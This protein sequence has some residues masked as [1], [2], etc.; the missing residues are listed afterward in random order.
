[1][2]KLLILFIISITIISCSSFG[3]KDKNIITPDEVL[4]AVETDNTMLLNNFF[5]SDFPIGYVNKEGKSLLIIA[6]EN[7]SQK[8]LNMLLG[9]GVYLEETF[10]DG[11]TPIFYVRSLNALEQMVKAGADINKK[12]SSGKTLLS[13]FIEAKPLSYS[14]YLTE[15]GADV[16]AVEENGWTP[17]FRA[18]AGRDISLLEAM[19]N[20][21]GNFT[22]QDLAGNFPI[23]YA[24]NEEILLKLLDSAKYNLNAKNKKEE[25]ILGEIYLRAVSYNYVSVIEKLLEVG[26]NPNYMSYGDSALSIARDNRNES[27]I[28][29]LNSKG[30]K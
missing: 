28:K 25:N 5:A 21:G 7:D 10:E 6:L 12:D 11:K 15:Q 14:K 3:S 9:K 1:M 22:K 16:N 27:M 17:V 2:K 29:Y 19:K 24:Q 23:Y 4:N 18:A 30:I 13:Y 20:N 26:V 8:V